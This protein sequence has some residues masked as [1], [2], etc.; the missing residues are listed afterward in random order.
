MRTLRVVLLST[1]FI[2]PAA[3]PL[4]AAKPLGAAVPGIA[5]AP[6]L[7]LLSAFPDSPANRF[8]IQL[9][10]FPAARKALGLTAPKPGDDAAA[11]RYLN[12]LFQKGSA[13]SG[14]FGDT[15][16]QLTQWRNAFGFSALDVTRIAAAGKPP[17]VFFGFELADVKAVDRAVR[18]DPQWSAV[19]KTPTYNSV[20][21]YQWGV[22]PTTD[23][24]KRSVGRP[25]GI[26]GQLVLLGQQAVFTTADTQ[27]RSVIDAAKGKTA[28]LSD[29]ADGRSLIQAVLERG[30]YSLT[31][32]P[33]GFGASTRSTG[34]ALG[35]TALAPYAAVAVGFGAAGGKGFAVLAY[36]HA[37][38]ATAKTNEVR[39]RAIVATGRSAVRDTPWAS[40]AKITSTTVRG[41]VL[42]AVLA[43]D[44]PRF[45]LDALF[46]QDT[47]FR[48]A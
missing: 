13:L 28:R 30:A 36:A 20:R 15:L 34:D 8:G 32:Y 35:A 3:I 4:P 23:L 33:S 6:L 10:D 16:G 9:T 25:F 46:A 40:V 37:S 2:V 39:L 29:W 27:A 44:Q 19:L 18:A 11:I 41:K 48:I 22:E 45:A 7:K 38:T 43:S 5:S 26:G 31:V 12:Q 42:I 21:Y 14:G 17:E 1:A 24:A 47:L